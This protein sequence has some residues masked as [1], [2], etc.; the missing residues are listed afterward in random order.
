MNVTI[1]AKKVTKLEFTELL[2][3]EIEQDSQV[4]INIGSDI[5]ANSQNKKLFRIKYPVT[6]TIRDIIRVS[7]YYEFDFATDEEITPDILD[8]DLVKIKAPSLAYPY[9]K[10]YLENIIATSGYPN[11]NIPFID[12]YDTPLNLKPKK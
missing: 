4:N 10:L 11:V 9:I 5:F 1:I 6:L 7:I 8:S 12:F 3:G 2:K